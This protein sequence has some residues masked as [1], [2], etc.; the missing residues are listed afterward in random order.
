M[1]NDLPI[2]HSRYQILRKLA[3][4]GF[5]TVYLAQDNLY[6]NQCVVKKLHSDSDKVEIM[7]RLFQEEATIL[8][9]LDHPQIP[10]LIDNFEENKEY[11][12]VQEYIEGH[13]LT[14]E[15]IP[16]QPWAENQVIELLKE[17]LSILEYIHS[18]GVIHRDIK[19][20][21]FIRRRQDGKLVLIDFGAVKKFNV[22]QSQ[23][24]NKTVT[25]GTYGYMPIEQALGQPRKNSDIYA[26]GMIGIQ[27]LTGIDVMALKQ[28]EQGEIIWQEFAQVTS[29]LA[30]IFTQMVRSHYLHRYQ[31]ATE[32][33]KALQSKSTVSNKTRITTPD[34]LYPQND[35]QITSFVSPQPSLVREDK[36]QISASKPKLLSTILTIIF[37]VLFSITGGFYYLK[38]TQ[39]QKFLT[40]LKSYQEK[41]QYKECFDKAESK[42]AQ[43]IIPE[44]RLEYIG[45]CRLE[46]AKKQAQSL[47]YQEAIDIAQ[48]IAVNNPFYQEAEKL[49]FDWHKKMK[50]NEP[51]CNPG[52]ICTC[53]GL[54]CPDN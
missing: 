45:Q 21:N 11:Y 20:D 13:T 7:K 51:E 52:V 38:Y 12:L 30:S 46:E 31:S 32:A 22:E 43:T 2:L 15:L 23:L 34:N 49:T 8:Q 5:G 6:Q 16:K 9:K 26:L 41:E 10:H 29:F 33:L 47:N 44:Q 1:N 53:P 54:L 36:L 28:D 18:R 37:F 40:D 4:G 19:P 24:I 3:E 25:V 42:E 27:A 48:A 14:K 35:H 39:K 50:N 17:G